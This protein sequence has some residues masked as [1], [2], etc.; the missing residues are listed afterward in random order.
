MSI[1]EKYK[2]REGQMR[3][4]E[5]V[6]NGRWY[7][8]DG[9]G[10]GWGDLTKEDLFRIADTI[11]DDDVFYVVG[12]TDSYFNSSSTNG[13]T[14]QQVKDLARFTITAKKVTVHQKWLSRLEMK[15]KSFSTLE[16]YERE[17]QPQ[18]RPRDVVEI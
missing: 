18:I 9:V 13:L 4:N 5:H 16:E 6:H 15:Q 11:S 17:L 8:R 14:L 7:G 12:E 3:V 10:I 2:L 1:I